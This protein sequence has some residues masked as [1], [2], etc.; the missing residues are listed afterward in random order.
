MADTCRDAEEA[1]LR[2]Q[3]FSPSPAALDQEGKRLSGGF[4]PIRPGRDA[5]ESRGIPRPAQQPR[6]DK[7]RYR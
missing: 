7:G 3:A 1:R 5:E 4:L 6:D 2:G